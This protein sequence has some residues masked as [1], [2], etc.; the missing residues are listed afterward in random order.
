MIMNKKMVLSLLAAG[1]VSSSMTA[2][3]LEIAKKAIQD[4]Q[5]DKAKAILRSLVIDKP[6]DGKNYYYLGDV[7]LME[8]QVDS[9]RFFFE[10]G[11][12]VKI[13]GFLNNIGLGQLALEA[14][15]VIRAKEFLNK[16]LSEIRKKDYDEQLL[17]ANAYLNSTNSLPNE[18]QEIASAIIEKDYTIAE[19][20]NVMGKAYMEQKNFNEAFSSFRNAI[21]YDDSLLDAKLQMAII[22]KRGRGYKE[23]IRVCEEILAI[24]SNYAPAF[25]EIA[26]NYYLW[27]QRDS[28]NEKAYLA[29]A[30][31]NYKKYIVASDNATEAQMKYADFLLLTENYKALEELAV[32]LKNVKGINNR[33]LRYSGYALY[34]NGK[35]KEAIDAMTK[36]LGVSS[37][38]IGR[39]YLYLGLSHIALSKDSKENYEEGVKNLKEAIKVEPAIAGEFNSLG[40]DLYRKSKYKQA[41][42]IL[43]ISAEVNDQPNVSY[44]NYYT[45][46][47]YYQL[48]SSDEE[49]HQEDLVKADHYFAKTIALDSSIS[50]A[51][52]FKARTNRYLNT[53]RA[54]KSVFEAYQGFIKSLEDK[55]ELKSPNY[56]DQVIEA[57]TSIATYYANNEKNKEAIDIFNKVLSIDSSNEFAKNT[58]QALQ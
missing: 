4:E 1:I 33:I 2:Q 28:S 57:Y 48:G 8:E 37:K 47:C 52:F 11:I 12:A 15:D 9:A 39:D 3:D 31:E 51:Y 53:E 50:E 34:K 13:K 23:A 27:S 55:G 44:D 38:A 10:K 22:T 16:A 24:N 36:F 20:H 30:T 6:N 26:D 19:A 41:I 7:F 58:I 56:Q 40:V 25:R 45:A 35:Y 49:K 46:Y 14:N 29:K 21:S 5:L 17:V 42:D 32:N 43:S 54:S 18:A